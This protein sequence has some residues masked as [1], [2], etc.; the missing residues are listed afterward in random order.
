MPIDTISP[1]FNGTLSTIFA[2]ASTDQVMHMTDAQQR[3]HSA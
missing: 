2:L 1:T 3:T